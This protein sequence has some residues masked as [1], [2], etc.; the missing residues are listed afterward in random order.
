MVSLEYGAVKEERRKIVFF[1]IVSCA[2]VF[3]YWVWFIYLKY[4]MGEREASEE[5]TVTVMATFFVLCIILDE[6]DWSV[7][8]S[9]LLLAAVSSRTILQDIVGSALHYC[10]G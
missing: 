8:H 7:P 3:L 6:R 5:V 4:G 1:F 10:V 2:V 9:V